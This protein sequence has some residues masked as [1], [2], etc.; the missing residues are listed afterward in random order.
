MK[1]FDEF[2]YLWTN[3]Q[4]SNRIKYPH[5]IFIV[6]YPDKL[7]W[8]FGVEKQTQTTCLQISGGMTG[9]GTGHDVKLM[10]QSELHDFLKTCTQTHAMITTVGM[11]FELTATKTSIMEFHDFSKSDRHKGSLVH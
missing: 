2:K 8:D 4:N 11:V 5:L 3:N 1:N 6:V 10:Y 7:E 9:A